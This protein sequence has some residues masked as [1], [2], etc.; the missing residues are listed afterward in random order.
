MNSFNE[1][2]VRRDSHGKFANKPGATTPPEAEVEPDLNDNQDF[3]I[4][5]RGRDYLYQNLIKAPQLDDA[6]VYDPKTKRD[7]GM[8]GKTIGLNRRF[9]AVAAGLNGLTGVYTAT[10]AA[11]DDCEDAEKRMLDYFQNERGGGKSWTQIIAHPQAQE[12]VADYAKKFGHSRMLNRRLGMAGVNGFFS[13]PD[14]KL[15]T[16]EASERYRE[17]IGFIREHGFFLSYFGNKKVY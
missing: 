11:L 10:D 15:A 5:Y 14:P 6:E 8:G 2:N 9:S 12:V 3:E 1:S 16:D 7:D 13:D 17:V 4:E